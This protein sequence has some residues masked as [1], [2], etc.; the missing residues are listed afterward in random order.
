MDKKIILRYFVP[1]GILGLGALVLARFGMGWLPYPLLIAGMILAGIGAVKLRPGWVLSSGGLLAMALALRFAA[2][3]YAW[4]GYALAF[5]AALIV[6]HHFLPA[7]L[8]RVVVVLVC[9]GVLYFCFVESFVIRSARTDK[10]PER[11]YLIV[12]GA[13]VYKDQPSLTLVRRLEGALDYLNTY[14]KSVAIVSGGMGPGETVTEAKAMHDWL[15]AHGIPEER[16]LQEPRATS[17]QENLAFSFQIIRE[18]GDEPD[19]HVAIV[20]SAYH[21]Y[22]AKEMAKLQGVEAAGVAAPWGYFFV[23]LNY[24]IREAFGVTHLWV[25]GN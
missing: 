16:I 7:K 22:R 23:M 3:G 18:R 2:R 5:V 9:I 1:A 10:E 11:D 14:P 19:G 15:I 8:W 25:F 12:L 20:S 4:W 21:L 24:F 6:L 17:T 13:A